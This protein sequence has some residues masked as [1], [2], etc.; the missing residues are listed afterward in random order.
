[1]IP[2]HNDGTLI[3]QGRL[4]LALPVVVEKF[5]ARRKASQMTALVLFALA[6]LFLCAERSFHRQREN[7]IIEAEV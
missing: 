1:L 6:V 4:S 3:L 5:D 7:M 2:E